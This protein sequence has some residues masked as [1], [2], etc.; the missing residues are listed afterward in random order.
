MLLKLQ[1]TADTQAKNSRKIKL[2]LENGRPIGPILS[3]SASATKDSKSAPKFRSLLIDDLPIDENRHIELH[4]MVTRTKQTEISVKKLNEDLDLMH[5]R[6]KSEIKEPEAI[7][8]ISST[9]NQEYF[10]SVLK[11]LLEN[12]TL[13]ATNKK[14]LSGSKPPP[15]LQANHLRGSS[16]SKLNNKISEK[17]VEHSGISSLRR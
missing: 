9:K 10:K 11:D 5:V 16:A 7:L 8:P 12:D 6:I 1:T 15:M 14:Y 4:H 17:K 13:D 2:A 3:K